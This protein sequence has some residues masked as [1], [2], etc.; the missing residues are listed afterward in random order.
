MSAS[1][2]AFSQSWP[3]GPYTATLTVPT[4]RPG[5]ALSAC[6]EWAPYTPGQLPADHLA[7]YRAGRDAAFAAMSRRLGIRAAVVE[8]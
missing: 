2:A 5:S 1:A 7:Q 8:L 3:V 6:I 4:L